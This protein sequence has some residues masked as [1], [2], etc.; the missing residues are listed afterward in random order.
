[1]KKFITSL[2]IISAVYW[3]PPSYRFNIVDAAESAPESTAKAAQQTHAWMIETY[4]KSALSYVEGL[5]RQVKSDISLNLPQVRKHLEIYGR[6]SLQNLKSAKM[7][8][9]EHL[10]AFSRTPASAEHWAPED[11]SQLRANIDRSISMNETLWSKISDGKKM[12]GE[13]M[14][15][16]S[17][18]RLREEV[19]QLRKQLRKTLGDTR[20]FFPL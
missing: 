6:E 13:S 8:A 7:H 1:M 2:F 17:R 18:D 19:S 3:S 14:S 15:G 5:E 20:D 4:L 9:K 11:L 16:A 10:A 12:D